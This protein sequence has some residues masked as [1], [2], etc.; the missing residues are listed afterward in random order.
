MRQRRASQDLAIPVFR[1][2]SQFEPMIA[3]YSD[4]HLLCVGMRSPLQQ[5]IT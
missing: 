2:R 5:R 3:V 4:M 1:V